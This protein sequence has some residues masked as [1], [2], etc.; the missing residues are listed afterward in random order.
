MVSESHLLKQLQQKLLQFD[1]SALEAIAN[2]GLL[3]RAKKDLQQ[4]EVPVIASETPTAIKMRVADAEVTMPEQGITK[5]SCT[6]P[7]VDVCRHILIA[8]LWLAETARSDA[9]EFTENSEAGSERDSIETPDRTAENLPNPTGKSEELL[10]YRHED[11]VK[12]AGRKTVQAAREL[13]GIDFPIE[14]EEAVPISIRLHRQNVVCRYFPNMGLEGM[15]CSCKSRQVCR[16]LVAAVLSYQQSHGIAIATSETSSTSLQAASGSPRSRSQV[17][18]AAMQLL[19]ECVNVGLCHLSEAIQQRFTTLAVSA[20]GVNLPR[21]SLMLRSIAD[22]LQLSR[23]RDVKADETRLFLTAARTYALCEAL[24]NGFSQKQE[25]RADLIGWH[26]TQY[27][28]VGT[29]DLAGLGAYDW[30]TKSGYAGLTVLFWDLAA[31]QWCCWSE[32]RPTFQGTGFNPQVRYRQPSAWEGLSTP[33]QASQTQFKLM[34][35]KRNR[36]NRLSSSSKTRAIGIAAVDPTQIDFADRLFH[37]WS[38]LRSYAATTVRSG[39]S[40]YDLLREIVVIRPRVWGEK[41]FDEMEQMFT[42]LVADEDGQLLPLQVRFR[43]G[44]EQRIQYLE[45]LEPEQVG[46]WGIVGQIAIARS[47][48]SLYPISLLCSA[49]SQASSHQPVVNLS[50]ALATKHGSS[51]T[52]TT[53]HENAIATGAEF[54]EIEDRLEIPQTSMPLSRLEQRLEKLTAEIQGMAEQGSSRMTE[55]IANQWQLEA[56]L[57]ESVGLKSLAD[58]LNGLAREPQSRAGYILRLRYLCLL[59]QEVTVKEYLMRSR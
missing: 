46:V 33:E 18:V 14:I 51:S 26:R 9:T 29:L 11:L 54:E 49:P 3:R 50:F 37:S 28:E 43:A 57:F 40:E 21:L 13:V 41:G 8:S 52:Q 58:C 39:L 7:A 23:D 55:A 31:K 36:L 34:A 20:T 30:V 59:C 32:A 4:G 53:Q 48:L 16:H 12:W 22:E 42:W 47:G 27:E 1:D 19:R 45:A 35:A 24:L 17:L 15:V 25:P 5:A 6:C 44:E 10:G 38:A 2:K 56:N